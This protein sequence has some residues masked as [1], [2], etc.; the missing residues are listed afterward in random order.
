MKGD[1][2]VINEHPDLQLLHILAQLEHPILD[3][4]EHLF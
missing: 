1:R 4:S 2:L 3:Q